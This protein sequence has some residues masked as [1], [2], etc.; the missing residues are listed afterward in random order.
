MAFVEEFS[1][2]NCGIRVDKRLATAKGADSTHKK[3]SSPPSTAAS[4][5]LLSRPFGP[6]TLPN[7]FPS[8]LSRRLDTAGGVIRKCYNLRDLLVKYRNPIML[9]FKGVANGG[10]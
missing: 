7:F 5:N 3:L 10:D 4:R 8:N 6:P 1:T 2:A 9:A